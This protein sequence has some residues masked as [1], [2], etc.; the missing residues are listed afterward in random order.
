[1]GEAALSEERLRDVGWERGR[2][3]EG[4]MAAGRLEGREKHTQTHLLAPNKY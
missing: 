3:R 2:R 1:M 4:R